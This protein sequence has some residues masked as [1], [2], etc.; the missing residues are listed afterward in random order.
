[1]NMDEVERTMRAF[2]GQLELFNERLRQSIAELQDHHAGVSPLWQDEMRRQ[3]DVKWLPLEEAMEHYTAVIGPTYVEVLL[4]KLRH[5]L[6]Y[7][8]GSN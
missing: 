4:E 5:L 1:M 8:H 6:R 2:E 3:Y 7:L